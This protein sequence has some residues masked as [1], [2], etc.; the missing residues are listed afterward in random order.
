MASDE[1]L[2][3]FSAESPRKTIANTFPSTQAM[4][5]IITTAGMTSNPSTT[6]TTKTVVTDTLTTSITSVSSKSL[7]P[8]GK[9]NKSL[10]EITRVES[11]GESAGGEDSELD[12]T[13][14]ETHDSSSTSVSETLAKQKL[15]NNNKP[16][17]TLSPTS[18]PLTVETSSLLTST[19][20]SACSTP[21]GHTPSGSQITEPTSRF[22]IVKILKE[23]P[24]DKGKW[25]ISDFK[26]SQKHK[27][28]STSVENP[29]SPMNKRSKSMADSG[30]DRTDRTKNVTSPTE[31]RKTKSSEYL[32]QN[33]L[34][35]SQSRGSSYNT[36]T[37]V[38]TQQ[39]NR[40]S[41]QES[42]SLADSCQ[43]PKVVAPVVV[44]LESALDQI[45]IIK[46]AMLNAVNEEMKTL[47]DSVTNL[48]LENVHLK[49]E[50]QKLK[51]RLELV[52]N[53]QLAS[54]NKDAG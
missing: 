32:M 10:F 18:K 33:V 19:T 38:S 9:A 11:H 3:D 53:K 25:A 34:S 28:D 51:D 13:L 2:I 15:D 1:N 43:L 30:G 52:E 27:D 42:T 4:P 50:N 24:Y 26:D 6:E 14:S 49:E 17:D 40:R 12:D 44:A 31:P 35:Q 21:S 45:Q 36:T 22:R 41:S 20:S 7:Q 47:R 16:I 54:E 29:A 46:D 5:P 39:D 23:K 48:H 37:T 8:P